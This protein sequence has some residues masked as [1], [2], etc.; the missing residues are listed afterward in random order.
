MWTWYSCLRK[1]K[2]RENGQKTITDSESKSAFQLKSLS[3][4]KSSFKSFKLEFGQKL[5]KDGMLNKKH[6]QL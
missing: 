5:K 1:Q 3:C 2:G 4:K 6:Q